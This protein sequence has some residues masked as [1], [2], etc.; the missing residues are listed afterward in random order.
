MT[1]F[2]ERRHRKRRRGLPAALGIPYTT[3]GW[4]RD[5]DRITTGP[6]ATPEDLRRRHIPS[7]QQKCPERPRSTLRATRLENI[8]VAEGR[9]LE[10]SELCV[11]PDA[12]GFPYAGENPEAN[13]TTVGYRNIARSGRS[14]RETVSHYQ[15]RSRRRPENWTDVLHRRI[16]KRKIGTPI[17]KDLHDALGDAGGTAPIPTDS[18]RRFGD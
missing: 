5:R 4:D 7:R 12:I 15:A 18:Y 17:A 14:P 13:G 9:W 1:D 11:Q 8:T 16:A 10:T 6:G 3:A 2:I